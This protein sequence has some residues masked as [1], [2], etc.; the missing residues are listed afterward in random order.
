MESNNQP[1]E[2]CI[3]LFSHLKIFIFFISIIGG[4]ILLSTVSKI[5]NSKQ[6]TSIIIALSIIMIL[7]GII[8]LIHLYKNQYLLG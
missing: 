5:C 1:K 4:I 8:G 3:N 6:C 7:I 2:L